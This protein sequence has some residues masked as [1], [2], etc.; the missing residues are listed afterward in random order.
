M[1]T[2]QVTPFGYFFLAAL[3]GEPSDGISGVPFIGAKTAL[4]LA[5]KLQNF[6]P[7]DTQ[8]ISNVIRDESFLRGVLSNKQFDSLQNNLPLFFRNMK[9]AFLNRELPVG[10]CFIPFNAELAA[11]ACLESGLVK[12]SEIVRQSL[13]T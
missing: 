8:S 13:T 10:D 3:R 12:V 4:V 5:Q 7:D 6:H 1:E 9:V 11:K 2:K